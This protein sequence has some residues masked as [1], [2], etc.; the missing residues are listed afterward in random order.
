MGPGSGGWGWGLWSAVLETPPPPRRSTVS[1]LQLSFAKWH[2]FASTMLFPTHLCL[3]HTHLA[4]PPVYC[5]PAPEQL[6]SGEGTQL[7]WL[8]SLQIHGHGFQRTFH[9]PQ[10]YCIC[11]PSTS[12]LSALLPTS[13]SAHPT[14]SPSGPCLVTLTQAPSRRPDPYPGK[15]V[16]R[17][18]LSS[19]FLLCS[20]NGKNQQETG[21]WEGRVP[22]CW[23]M[24]WWWPHLHTT[25]DWAP[26]R[27]PFVCYNLSLGFWQLSFPWTL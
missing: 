18:S 5:T 7:C 15:L 14:P 12:T 19:G 24:N 21:G 10:A 6:S 4:K 9:T 8:I 27:Q 25:E 11:P 22:P 13:S 26:A 1:K 3:S 20:A 17:V 23:V 16:F 2:F